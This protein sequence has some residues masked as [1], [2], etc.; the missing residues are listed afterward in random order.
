M[1]VR[2]PGRRDPKSPKGS[3]TLETEVWAITRFNG[4]ALVDCGKTVGNPST[5]AREAAPGGDLVPVGLGI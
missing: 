4:R 1:P 3:L 2:S 5:M